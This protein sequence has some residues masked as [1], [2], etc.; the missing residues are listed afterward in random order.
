MSAL[1]SHPAMRAM[2]A[3]LALLLLLPATALGGGLKP[4]SARA[5]VA[6][7]SLEDLKGRRVKLSSHKGK[8][9]VVSFWATWCVPCKQELKQLSKLRKKLEKKGF[10]VLAISVDGPETSSGVRGFVKRHRLEMPVLVDR[11]GSFSAFVNPRGSTPFSL[12]VDRSGRVAWTHEG[13][14]KGDEVVLKKHV[15]ALLEEPAP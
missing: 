13:F 2:L 5:E 15:E 8:V 11:D 3:A 12:L 10:E 14:A 7:F 6:R 1:P 9:L 4:A